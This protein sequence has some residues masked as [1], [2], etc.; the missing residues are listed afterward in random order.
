MENTKFVN[1]LVNGFIFENPGKK[2]IK[3][4]AKRKEEKKGSTLVCKET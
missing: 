2:K 4:N 1:H 3:T